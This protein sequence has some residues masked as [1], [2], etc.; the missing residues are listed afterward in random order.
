M[1]RRNPDEWRVTPA[2]N[3]PYYDRFG[4]SNCG[5]AISATGRSRSQSQRP[6]ATAMNGQAFVSQRRAASSIWIAERRRHH[7]VV[8]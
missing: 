7:D 2:A 1:A 4:A 5:I 6:R 3:P 8:L